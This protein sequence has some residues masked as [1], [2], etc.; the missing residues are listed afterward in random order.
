[1]YIHIY[2]YMCSTCICKHV[3]MYLIVESDY[4]RQLLLVPSLALRLAI[5]LPLPLV[6]LSLNPSGSGV[7][8]RQV[9]LYEC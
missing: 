2:E 3:Y 6:P 1:M 8:Y 9:C 5:H 4:I 7:E